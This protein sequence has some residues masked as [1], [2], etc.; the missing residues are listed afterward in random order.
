MSEVKH[1]IEIKWY[2]K[3][4]L[5]RSALLGLMLFTVF[6]GIAKREEPPEGHVFERLPA[7][8]G[9]YRC[10]EAGGRYSK[11]WVGRRGVNC[12]GFSYYHLGTGRNDCGFKEQL[13]GVQVVVEQVLIP[14]Y[15][16]PLPLVSKIGAGGNTYYEISDGRIRELWI[17][18]SQKNAFTLAFILGAVFHGAQLILIGRQIRK[19]K[20]NTK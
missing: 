2:D 8:S 19:F 7:I 20:G 9:V 5:I 12:Q 15:D 6:W 10:C 18:G 1:R 17:N 13:D 3:K 11:S 14:A 4:L 16:G